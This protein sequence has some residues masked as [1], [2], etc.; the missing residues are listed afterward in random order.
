V[1][2]RQTTRDLGARLSVS[3]STISSRIRKMVDSGAI[4]FAVLCNPITLGF[5][6]TV[7]FGLR[8]TPAKS[9]DVAAYLRGCRSVQMLSLTAGRYDLLIYAVFRDN[10]ELINWITR[11]PDVTTAEGFTLL[12]VVR[13]SYMHPPGNRNSRVGPLPGRLDELD[14]KLIKELEASPRETIG[15]LESKTGIGRKKIATK[16]KTLLDQRAIRVVSIVNPEVFGFA[17]RAFVFLKVEVDRIVPVSRFLATDKRI[18]HVSIINGRFNVMLH[19]GFSCPEDLSHFVG[20]ELVCI[21]G[22]IDY[23][24]LINTGP[25]HFRWRLLS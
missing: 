23:E 18:G 7:V 9:A 10:R 20:D 21:P 19:A 13:N 1:N 15:N 12:Q 22:I 16:I 2:A 11:L 8:A 14:L 5:Q 25:Q 17:L 3:A 24:F 4:T 6:N